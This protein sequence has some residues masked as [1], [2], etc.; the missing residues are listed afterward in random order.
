MTR[1]DRG[2]AGATL[3]R[4]GATFLCLA[5]LYLAGGGNL[6]HQHSGA[7]AVCHVCQAL[8]APALTIAFSGILSAPQ[9]SGW[10]SSRPVFAAVSDEFS[11]LR[12]GRAPP[13]A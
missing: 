5:L 7:D 2:S 12:A 9:I 1:S 10:H 4:I 8:H 6:L 11:L 13:S 3:R